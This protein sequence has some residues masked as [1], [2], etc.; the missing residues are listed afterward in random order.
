MSKTF[1]EHTHEHI[2]SC[3]YP[4]CGIKLYNALTQK[5]CLTKIL[6]ATTLRFFSHVTNS[7]WQSVLLFQ[8]S[9]SDLT[10]FKW[11]NMPWATYSFSHSFQID[12]L[13]FPETQ[14]PPLYFSCFLFCFS[15]LKMTIIYRGTIPFLCPC[16]C[17]NNIRRQF[18]GKIN[19]WKITF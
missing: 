13:Y 7:L 11:G 1:T 10:T 3:K 2:I 16:Q 6:K 17:L 4:V 19:Y 9:L 12:T 18:E 8:N 15:T 5:H 14:F